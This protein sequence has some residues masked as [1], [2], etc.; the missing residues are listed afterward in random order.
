MSGIT[1]GLGI[2]GGIADDLITTKEEKMKAEL[3]FMKVDAEL[4]K[5]QLEINKAEAQHKSI[6]V[7]GWRP[8]IGWVCGLAF[9]YN[10]VLYPIMQ[11]LSV[12]F[13]WAQVD[14]LPHLNISDMMPVLL[15]MLGL[16]G[17]RTYEKQRG[18][19]S[20]SIDDGKKKRGGFLGLGRRK[21]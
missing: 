4:A 14:D 11:Y 8:F 9:A 10:F 7:A 15:G 21:K 13:D 5:G 12:V 2:L 20:D 17:L 6:F 16:G 19:N 3:E 1:K 18:V